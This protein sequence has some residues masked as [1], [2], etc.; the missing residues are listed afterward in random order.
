VESCPVANTLGVETIFPRRR[1][2]PLI[3]ALGVVGIVLVVVVFGKLSGHWQSSVT[4][5]Q[6]AQQI[7]DLQLADPRQP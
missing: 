3:V 6:M 7:Q 2:K 1:I 4:A 5:P